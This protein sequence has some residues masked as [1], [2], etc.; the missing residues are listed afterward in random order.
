MGRFAHGL[1]IG[2][3]NNRAY[4]CIAAPLY[5]WDKAG[6]RHREHFDAIVLH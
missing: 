2:H 6:A 1:M 5:L 3:R 4:Q